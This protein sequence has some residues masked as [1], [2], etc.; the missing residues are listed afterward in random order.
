MLQYLAV[1]RYQL[2]L[3]LIH[4]APGKKNTMTD[5]YLHLQVR[6]VDFNLKLSRIPSVGCILCVPRH[7]D[8]FYPAFQFHS[9]S[10]VKTEIL[11]FKGKWLLTLDIIL[12][13]LAE[14]IF[15]EKPMFC[16]DKRRISRSWCCLD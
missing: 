15:M 6:L 1:T 5:R 7:T 11:L 10:G 12:S 4:R 8:F 14:I 13:D 9:I 3:S 16:R 2:S